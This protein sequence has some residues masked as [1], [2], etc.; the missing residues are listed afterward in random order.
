MQIVTL[1]VIDHSRGCQPP[2]PKLGESMSRHWQV[3][4][5]MNSDLYI[6]IFGSFFGF[7][8]LFALMIFMSSASPR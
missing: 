3:Q 6:V 5:K 4:R 1:Q 8:F 2:A 7:L